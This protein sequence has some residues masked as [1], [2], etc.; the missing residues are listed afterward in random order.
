MEPAV[1]EHREETRVLASGPGDVDPQVGLVLR[2]VKDVRAV[3]EHRRSGEAG[4]E[5]ARLRLS[6]V[7]DEVG[8]GPPGLV[9]E[10]G[11]AP[12]DIFIGQLV[13]V[14]ERRLE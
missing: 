4:I 6:D 2:E 12:K 5:P 1:R 10:I 3:H 14:G 13:K 8:L 9:Q 11:Q 7:A